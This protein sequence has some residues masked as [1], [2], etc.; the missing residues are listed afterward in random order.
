MKN[1]IKLILV[2]ALANIILLSCKKDNY[3]SGGQ[4]ENATTPLTTYDYLQSNRFHMFDTLLM[5]V[6]KAG[7]KDL[8]NQ[9]GVTFYAPSDYSIDNYLDAKTLEIQ[10]KFPGQQYSIDSLI[11][12]DLPKFADSIKTYIIPQT[13]TYKNLTQNGVV[14][15]TSKSGAKAVIS[16]EVTYDPSLGYNSALSTPPH[17]EYYNFVKGKLPQTVVASKLSDT[18]AVRVLCQTT[19]LT[20]ATGQLNVLSNSHVLYFKQ[21]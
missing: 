6:D 15:N 9:K 4:L 12:Y 8:I 17:V 1:I 7:V 3:I 16:F 11:K 19:G 21:D 14:Y 2:I 10:K 5:L 13:V 18:V 20:T